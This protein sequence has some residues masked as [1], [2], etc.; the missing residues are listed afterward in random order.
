MKIVEFIDKLNDIGYNEDTELVFNMI[1]D[2][3]DTCID[4][5]P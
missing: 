1:N 4:Y 2:N 5:Y 3:D